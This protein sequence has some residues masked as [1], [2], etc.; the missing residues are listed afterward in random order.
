MPATLE[1]GCFQQQFQLGDFVG[2]Q[3]HWVIVLES[4]FL[5]FIFCQRQKTPNLF[6]GSWLPTH[7]L[8][9]EGQKECKLLFDLLGECFLI[10]DDNLYDFSDDFIPL[11]EDHELFADKNLQFLNLGDEKG[12]VFDVFAFA[13]LDDFT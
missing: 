7:I 9:F 4:F 2:L 6:L 11:D 12:R 5:D 1:L 13:L 10:F 3:Q 8:F